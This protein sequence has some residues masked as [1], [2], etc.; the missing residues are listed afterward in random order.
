MSM[1]Q[2]DTTFGEIKI[3]DTKYR[4]FSRPINDES[5]EKVVQYK[6]EYGGFSTAPWIWD[7][8]VWSIID[9]KLYLE[10]MTIWQ[11]SIRNLNELIFGSDEPLLASWQNKD[12]EA[13]ISREEFDIENEPKQK[14]VKMKTKILTWAGKDL[15]WAISSQIEIKELNSISPMNC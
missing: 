8:Y 5:A 3:E 4:I 10:E 11:G 7:N 15:Q 6:K 9:N 2:Q 12:I 13:L 1:P 14:L